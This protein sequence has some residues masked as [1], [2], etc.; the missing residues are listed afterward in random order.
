MCTDSEG[1]MLFI[2][3]VYC[4]DIFQIQIVIYPVSGRQVHL[5]WKH[6]V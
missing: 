2:Y 4:L 6:I 1:L 5:P 3:Q